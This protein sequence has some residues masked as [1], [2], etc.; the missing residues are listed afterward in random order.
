MK[1]ATCFRKCS[2]LAVFPCEGWF[3]RGWAPTA[4]SEQGQ[5][6]I[7]AVLTPVGSVGGDLAL[8]PW[9]SPDFLGQA[10]E[11]KWLWLSSF[12]RV[13]QA[14]L[15][16]GWGPV[17]HL[18]TSPQSGLLE[19]FHWSTVLKVWCYTRQPWMPAPNTTA[20]SSRLTLL[21]TP[22]CICSPRAHLVPSLPPA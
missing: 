1:E 9:A 16:K 15:H 17:C 11:L 10:A 13:V 14:W 19:S 12:T 5:A 18:H 20:P 6:H 4:A 22:L 8:T 2:A 7:S 3:V 21:V